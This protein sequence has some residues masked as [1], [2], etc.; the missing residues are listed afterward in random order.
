MSYENE[1]ILSA[2]LW[3]GNKFDAWL[4]LSQPNLLKEIA[5]LIEKS[6]PSNCT[7]ICGLAKS[8]IPLSAYI[9]S[10][11]KIRL[12]LL[13]HKGDLKDENGN[14]LEVVPV[15]PKDENI[16]LLD[17]HIK[18]GTTAFKAYA[19]LKDKKVKPREIITVIDFKLKPFE[20]VRVRRLNVISPITIFGNEDW[21][22]KT[23]G[24]ESKN[25][26]D[27]I[28]NGDF[29]RIPNVEDT[30]IHPVRRSRS[31]ER[32]KPKIIDSELEK[33][34]WRFMAG[35]PGIG[36]Y[37]LFL[38]PEVLNNAFQRALSE[39]KG[40]FEVLVTCGLHGVAF[41]VWLQQILHS[42]GLDVPLHCID[43]CAPELRNHPD[44]EQLRGRNTLLF[45]S[46]ISTG[47]HAFHAYEVCSELKAPPNI[48]LCLLDCD[49]TPN[50]NR[51]H[52]LL[53]KGLDILALTRG[54]AAP[55][56]IKKT[57]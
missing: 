11:L 6:I 57:K 12:Y 3:R 29:W 46:Y 42:D 8:G 13:S 50:R 55:F 33:E 41:G 26:S 32:L 2:F 54:S 31:K 40:R 23:L 9:A 14:I 36:L 48:M 25:I 7:A 34:L 17:T 28:Q 30:R 38:E 20:N 24:T 53:K 45:D 43:H 37:S 22:A 52:S 15:P 1:D 10:K 56:S 21:V 35:S 27:I 5:K 51:V 4:P 18:T 44:L 19:I 47:G 39:I 16:V 49:N